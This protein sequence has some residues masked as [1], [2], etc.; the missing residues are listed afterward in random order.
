MLLVATRPDATRPD[1]SAARG[2]LDGSVMKRRVLLFSV[3]RCVTPDPVFPL[4]L[5]HLN[6]ALRASGHETRWHDVQS[7]GEALEPLLVEFAPHVVGISLRNIDD[8]LIR[9]QE[10]YY[11]DLVT[12]VARIRGV[13]ACTIV[14]GGS[15]FSLFPER[16]LELSGA[17]FGI[18]GEG[19][20]SFTELI[21]ALATG[22]PIGG[23]AGLV[24]RREGR[25]VV[26]PGGT[27]EA[28]GPLEEID[29]PA[30]L[31]AHYLGAGGMLNVQTQRGCAHTCCYCTYP[32]IEGRRNR[33]RE[34]E[35]VAE[36]FARIEAQGASYVFIVDSIFNSSPQHVAGM[37][38]AIRR[39]RLRL[40]WGCFLRPQGL[41]VE[42]MRLMREA[43]LAHA[44][45][46]SDSFCD[47]VLESYGKQLTFADILQSHQAARSAGVEACHFL[48]CGG[49]GETA[50]T[51]EEGHR[52][53]LQ[54][55]EAVIMA[56]VGMRIYPGTALHRRALREGRVT[57]TTDLLPPV[58][59]LAPGLTEEVV[60]QRLDEFRAR[61][62]N[63]IAGHPAPEYAKLV[64]RLRSRGVTGPL[65]SYFAVLQR[66]RPAMSQPAIVAT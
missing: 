22:G 42:L 52:H 7:P 16:L 38:E 10:T 21:E 13:H 62:P 36:E 45:F 58:Y 27:S 18:Q 66:L 44:E 48:I 60:F 53:S 32:L 49:P 4:G 8:V 1:V 64:Q 43:G 33:R 19:E 25:I 3:N 63:W 12:W 2:D 37:C 11:G 14:I 41:D 65:W 40:R 51:L 54:L 50:Q 5:A 28:M 9:K 23:I 55:D 35:D 29:R 46:G 56:M 30:A 34:P 24:E 39:R 57:E 31:V 61:S 6:A 47:S 15:G 59:Y 17:D 20:R 26:N